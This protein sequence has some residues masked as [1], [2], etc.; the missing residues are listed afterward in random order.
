[1]PWQS[2]CCALLDLY[3]LFR[4]HVATTL[5]HQRVPF[6]PV[7]ASEP[8]KNVYPW[9]LTRE[10]FDPFLAAQAAMRP[11]LLGERTVVRAATR[12]NANRDLEMLMRYPVLEG[13]HPNLRAQLEAVR[14]GNWEHSWYALPYSVRWAPRIL[15]AHGLLNGAAEDIE[16]EDG[17]FADYLRLRAR[18]LISDD[19]EGGDAA[20]VRGDFGNLN[21]QIGSYETYDDALYG[22]K[23]FFSLSV[24]ARDDEKSRE[25]ESV[26]GGIQEIQDGLPQDSARKVAER[27]P[28]GVY[29]V[30]ADFGQSRGSNTATILP[31]DADHSRKYGR[32]IL[33]RYNIMTHPDLFADT[34]AIYRAAVAEEHADDLTMEGGFY[35]TLWHEIGHYLGV[36][37]TTDGRD[38]GA[39]LSPYGDLLEE[40]KSDLVSLHTAPLLEK[41][42]VIDANTLR[43]IRASGIY[44]VL[45]RVKPRRDQPYQ[46]M[47]LMQM[48][49]FLQN[50][51][52]HFDADS[53]RLGIDY[54]RYPG[55]IDALLGEVL[56]VQANGDPGRAAAFIEE[57][58]NWDDALHG[59]LAKRMIEAAPYRFRMV[60]YEVLDQTTQE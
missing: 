23:S 6:L 25:L 5:D 16:M 58:G 1:M 33:L 35:R 24:L 12:E 38:L 34:D 19:Y 51:L 32:T 55:V 57:Y 29:N 20:W 8:G 17:D 48:N 36:A 44:R 56:A 3:Y 7:R 45:Q 39:A 41:K 26:I 21:A 60:T 27:I 4:G 43:A 47:Q 30:I 11:A 54:E 28:V 2:C 49:F 37:K 53:G 18:D 40:M 42:G 14:Q 59:V 46:T 13:L 22:V 52:L 50:G 31:N 9:A 15:D 10:A